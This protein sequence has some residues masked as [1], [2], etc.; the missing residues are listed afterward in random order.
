M[1]VALS[2]LEQALIDRYLQFYLALSGGR[3]APTSVLQKQFIEVCKGHLAPQ[4]EH[5]V[6]FAKHVKIVKARREDDA[7]RRALEKS[8]RDNGV[9][10]PPG[11]HNYPSNLDGTFDSAAKWASQNGFRGV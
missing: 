10:T 2:E 7:A 6:A 11:Q 9:E 8:A 1:I 4:T 3:R 5:E